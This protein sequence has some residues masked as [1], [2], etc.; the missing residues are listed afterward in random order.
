MTKLMQFPV[1]LVFTLGLGGLGSTQELSNPAFSGNKVIPMTKSDLTGDP[2]KQVI[3][4]TYE[5]PA[6]SMV[7]RH[8]HPGDEFHLVLSGEW[9]AE[10]H[11]RP[12]QNLKAGQSQ[13]VQR[14]LWHGGRVVGSE[15]LRLL[16]LM[17][18][19]K[20]KPVTQMVPAN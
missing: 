3:A 14:G 11:G 12:T 2:T 20:D 1:A 18:V 5:V 17:I 19:D 6:G 16:G 10:V 4:N 15:P 8:S 9:E 13:Y 7:P